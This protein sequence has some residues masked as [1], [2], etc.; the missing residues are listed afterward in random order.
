M[1]SQEIF[2]SR[3]K[4]IRTKNNLTLQELGKFLNVTKQTIGHWETGIRVPPLEKTCL[5][6]EY[7]DVS[8][9]YLVGRSDNPN[10]H[11]L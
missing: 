6:A 1:F 9:D 8:I 10:S 3:L 4:E 2:S 11:K 5:L 7:F